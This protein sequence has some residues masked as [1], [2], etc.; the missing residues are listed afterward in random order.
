MNPDKLN[1]CSSIRNSQEDT[2][3]KTWLLTADISI[4]SKFKHNVYYIPSHLIFIPVKKHSWKS[5]HLQSEIKKH[6]NKLTIEKHLHSGCIFQPMVSR[7]LEI[8][9][10]PYKNRPCLGY[11]RR[12]TSLR[13]QAWPCDICC[14][15]RLLGKVK[16]RGSKTKVNL[17][18]T[19]FFWHLLRSRVPLDE[20]WMEHV[21]TWAIRM[22]WK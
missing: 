9:I 16:K 1:F 22:K 8:P 10:H 11:Q 4:H 2:A 14:S 6:I 15:F 13:P 5:T 7:R 12:P 21:W 19:C 18:C 20:W 17:F 3:D